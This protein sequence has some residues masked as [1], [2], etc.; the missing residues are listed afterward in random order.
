MTAYYNYTNENTE[1]LPDFN[2]TL[3]YEHGTGTHGADGPFLVKTLPCFTVNTTIYT[4]LSHYNVFDLDESPSLFTIHNFHT[5]GEDCTD[6]LN[7][8]FLR[9]V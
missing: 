9:Y 3:L 4:L 2:M 6:L 8:N 1:F 7:F 5:T